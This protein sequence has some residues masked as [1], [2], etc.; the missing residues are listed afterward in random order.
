M[1]LESGHYDWTVTSSNSAESA[2]SFSRPDYLQNLTSVIPPGTDLMRVQA[3]ISYTEF[4]LSDPQS[5]FLFWHNTFRLLA[6]DWQDKNHDG[7][8]WTD[9]NANGAVQ[10]G[11]NSERRI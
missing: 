7:Q 10:A 6:Y 8:L 11:R 3:V 2:G 4:T 5:Q 1:L 9:S